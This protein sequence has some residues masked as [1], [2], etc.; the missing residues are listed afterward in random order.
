MPPGALRAGANVNGVVGCTGGAAAP[1]RGTD[2][3][4]GKRSAAR[5]G[6]PSAA[7]ERVYECSPLGA[8]MPVAGGAYK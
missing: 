1:A 6:K 3:G 7:R 5:L 8:F 2:T 4:I